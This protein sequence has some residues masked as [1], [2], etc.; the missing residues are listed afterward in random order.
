MLRKIWRAALLAR[1]STA[2]AVSVFGAV[3]RS[4]LFASKGVF[5]SFLLLAGLLKQQPAPTL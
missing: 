3:L 2:D 5:S 1:S 4:G